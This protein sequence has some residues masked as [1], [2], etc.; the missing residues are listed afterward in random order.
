M[1]GLSALDV[2]LDEQADRVTNVGREAIGDALGAPS[3]GTL[4]GRITGAMFIS[5]HRLTARA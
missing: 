4:S 5:T 3:A 1:A 2:V